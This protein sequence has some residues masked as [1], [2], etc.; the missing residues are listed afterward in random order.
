MARG[1][2]ICLAGILVTG[3]QT[4]P[5]RNSRASGDEPSLHI[6]ATDN[7]HEA[8]DSVLAGLRH[9]RFENHGSMIHEA[10]F[11]RLPDDMTA[12]DYAALVAGG[13]AFP[14]GAMDCSG[15]GL[16]SPGES[17]DMWLGLEPG[18]YMLA[19]WFRHAAGDSTFPQHVTRGPAREF[20]VRR[21]RADDPA[22]APDAN[23]RL[24]DYRFD[25]EG[26]IRPGTRTVRVDLTGPSMHE[27]DVYRL[28][29]GR[30][31]DDLKLWYRTGRK[32]APPATV[33][34]GV[35]DSHDPGRTV[36]IRREFVPGRYV[37]WCGMDMPAGAGAKPVTHADLG[38][39]LE[40]TVAD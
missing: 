6:V 21:E 1:A 32:T 34:G 7:G 23:I 11:I 14:K 8:P 20:V 18:R 13:E 17:L 39:V 31:L 26:A 28:H 16:T 27:M 25:L 30:E 4:T 35:L 10:M 22:P 9:A 24:V 15:P 5:E 33:L 12:A 37:A 3:C 29:D 38:M 40:F 36:W 2:S 19:C